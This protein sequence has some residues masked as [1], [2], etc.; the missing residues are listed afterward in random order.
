MKLF[1]NI[2]MKAYI[3]YI[4]TIL[5]LALLVYLIIHQNWT[6]TLHR[7]ALLPLW[8]FPICI[9]LVI[10]GMSLNSLRWYI[11]LQ[12]LGII[13]PYK[14]T[15]KIVFAGAFASNFLPSTIGGDIYRIISLL[16]FTSNKSLS[17]ASV[18]VD[19]SLN[20]FSVVILFP[21]SLVTL[22]TPGEIYSTFNKAINNSFIIYNTLFKLIQRYY[23]KFLGAFKVFFRRPH[24]LLLGLIVSWC[25]NLVIFIM[26]W[27]ISRELGISI[28]LFQVIGITVVTYLIT[29][30]PISIN[31]YGVREVAIITLYMSIGASLEQ[32]TTLA[33]ITR[34]FQLLESLP[35][36]LWL[37][38][39]ISIEKINGFSE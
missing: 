19:R 7:I 13:I 5:S 25:S 30:L 38:S 17:V 22:G 39:I 9:F 31:G 23:Q 24:Y 1:N 4:G 14:E 8:I 33:I 26:V 32:A 20:L 28:E 21:F 2:T 12:G 11:L 3:R 34:F 16:K 18:I 27:L 15:L 29:L 35:G 36:S 10:A 37:G 6:I